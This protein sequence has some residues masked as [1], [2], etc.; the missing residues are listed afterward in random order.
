MKAFLFLSAV[1]LIN[2]M[3]KADLVNYTPV[4]C[5]QVQGSSEG[6]N[7]LCFGSTSEDFSVIRLEKAGP[8][9][10]IISEYFVVQSLPTHAG[11]WLVQTKS[12]G[13]PGEARPFEMITVG[14]FGHMSTQAVILLN[15]QGQP[16][17]EAQQFSVPPPTAGR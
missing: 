12:I 16:D 11:S 2:S 9:G 8:A 14:P 5:S 6:I 17:G 4:L 10:V 13:T 15:S 1:F 7:S 3:A